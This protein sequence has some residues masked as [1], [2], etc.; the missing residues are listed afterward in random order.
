MHVVFN[1]LWLWEFGRRVERYQ[2]GLYLFGLVLMIGV[3]SNI[4]QYLHMPNNPFGG[5][6]GVNYG[7]LGYLWLRCRLAP[8]PALTLPPALVGFLLFFLVLGFTGGM[9]VLAGGAIANAAHL[10]G[11]IIG[12]LLGIID[13][14][15]FKEKVGRV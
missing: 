4:A 11:F 7:L 5:M 6:S 10:G 8:V 1:C 14:L 2:G 3:F 15:R 9:D 13:G 12:S